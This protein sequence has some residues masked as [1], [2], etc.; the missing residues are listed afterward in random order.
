MDLLFDIYKLM[1]AIQKKEKE[2]F[3]GIGL[4][5]YDEKTFD[6][7][8]HCDLRP[9]IKCPRYHITDD[10]ICDYLAEISNYDHDLHDGFHMANSDGYLTYVAQYFVPP[11][12]KNLMPNQS[13]GVRIYSSMCGSMIEG[14]VYIAT[15]S[16]DEKIFIFKNGEYANID[17][18]EER[19]LNE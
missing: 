18:L 4:V 1:R 6:S 11:I 13:H 15:I 16:S 3:S 5:I 12:I 8:R 2:K 17:E 14:V 10:K 19:L 9:E 7:N